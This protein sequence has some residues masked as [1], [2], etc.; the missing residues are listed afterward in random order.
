MRVLN[1]IDVALRYTELLSYKSY[2]RAF[3]YLLV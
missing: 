1:T 3:A 2:I